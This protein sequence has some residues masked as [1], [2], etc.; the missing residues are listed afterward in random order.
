MR[1]NLPTLGNTC[2]IAD[3]PAEEFD[4]DIS[5]DRR[6][7][8]TRCR[9]LERSALDKILKTDGR[10][11][12]L[13]A[14]TAFEDRA[15]EMEFGAGANENSAVLRW[16]CAVGIGDSRDGFE[17]HLVLNNR[18]QARVWEDLLDPT[19]PSVSHIEIRRR[20]IWK[21]PDRSTRRMRG[22]EK[23]HVGRGMEGFAAFENLIASCRETTDTELVVAESGGGK[24]KSAS[25]RLLI[26]GERQLDVQIL[27]LCL[28]FLI[29]L[30]FDLI[31]EI[32]ALALRPK[33][34]VSADPATDPMGVIGRIHGQ[35]H[36]VDENNRAWNDSRHIQWDGQDCFCREA[37]QARWI[38]RGL[39]NGWD[40]E[41]CGRVTEGE[42]W[43]G[44]FD[45]LAERKK[46]KKRSYA[47][48]R[49]DS[50][51][52]GPGSP[53]SELPDWHKDE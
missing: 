6:V 2:T 46:G 16:R 11:F 14:E 53:A 38:A 5:S 17:E 37:R 28:D 3:S 26:F 44:L 30:S 12:Q 42:E 8:V 23:A 51:A 25:V 10:E 34:L 29:F 9:F 45:T 13:D 15:R 7:A 27:K 32:L 43:V 50:S 48:T 41:L 31:V 18:I 39:R 40:R 35:V 33:L 52:G 22:I 4:Q 1:A 49:S 20:V 19:R 24:D 47:G 21:S 36:A